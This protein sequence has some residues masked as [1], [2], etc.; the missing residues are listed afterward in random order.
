M[1]SSIRMNANPAIAS[2]SK[3]MKREFRKSMEQLQMEMSE[4]ALYKDNYDFM[5]CSPLV[6]KL[7]EEIRFLDSKV[8]DLKYSNK[9]LTRELKN[10]QKNEIRLN[11]KIKKLRKSKLVGE[12]EYVPEVDNSNDDNIAVYNYVAE[13]H[14]VYELVENEFDVIDDVKDNIEKSDS[15]DEVKVENV[16]KPNYEGDE[17][18]AEEEEEEVENDK[19]AEEEETVENDGDAEEEEEKDTEEEVE[20]ENDGDAEEDVEKDTEEDVEKDTEEKLE[21]EAEEEVESEEVESEEVESEEVEVEAE[22]EAEEEVEA[23]EAEE[24]VENEESEEEEAEEEVEAEEEEVYEVKIK[25][26]SYFTTNEKSG[27]IY[28]MDADGDVGDEVGK[29]VNGVATFAK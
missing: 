26:K 16:E 18:D 14:I 1:S 28:A 10:M 27:V 11:K 17:E 22:E 13:E 21:D 29:Y 19:D 8:D 3:N 6:Q 12:T 23:E 5:M 7:R 24:E 4:Y 25:G 15:I 9:L 20:V 2:V